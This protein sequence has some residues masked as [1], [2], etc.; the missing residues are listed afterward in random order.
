MD[1]GEVQTK[2]LIR[3]ALDEG[4][5]VYVPRCDGSVMDMVRLESSHDLDTLPQNKWGIPEPSKDRPAVN[6]QVLDFIVVPGVAFDRYGNRCGHG[7]GYYDRYLAQAKQAFACAVC[8]NVQ[9]LD[10]PVP[11]NSYDQ[12]PHA[13]ITPSGMLFSTQDK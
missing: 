7:K 12:K 2:P 9:V 8:L 3:H 1:N 5:T 11:S 13:V 10:T 6:P 4:K